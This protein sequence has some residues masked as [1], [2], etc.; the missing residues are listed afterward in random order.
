MLNPL[1][2]MFLGAVMDL[3][4]KTVDY[5]TVSPTVIFSL[6]PEMDLIDL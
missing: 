3:R 6:L 1:G 4:K 5:V 2:K